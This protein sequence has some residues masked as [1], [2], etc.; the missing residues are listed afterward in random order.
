MVVLQPL[1][2]WQREGAVGGDNGQ[3]DAGS[4]QYP[5]NNEANKAPSVEFFH[6]I[7]QSEFLKYCKMFRAHSGAPWNHGP[8]AEATP[9]VIE[10]TID[11][12]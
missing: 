9:G 7:G 3:G 6:V 11:K 10:L 4:S 2:H 12:N 1:R 5:K 8:S